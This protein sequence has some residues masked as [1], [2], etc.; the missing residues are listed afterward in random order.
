MTIVVVQMEEWPIPAVIGPQALEESE[1]I[2]E[3][4]KAV[5]PEG[6]RVDVVVPGEALAIAD[7][8]VTEVFSVEGGPWI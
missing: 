2:C 7:D 1:T 8:I 5:A 6:A 4:L 3:F